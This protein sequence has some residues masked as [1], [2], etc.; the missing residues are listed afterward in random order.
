MVVDIN[1]D[2][3]GETASRIVADGGEAAAMGADVS[4][5]DAVSELVADVAAPLVEHSLEELGGGL[6]ACR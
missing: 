3:A 5:A 2:A 1:R 6:T 4:I